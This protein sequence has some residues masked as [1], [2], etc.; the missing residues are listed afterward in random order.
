MTSEVASALAVLAAG[1]IAVLFR[2]HHWLKDVE[3]KL[4]EVR[5]E[6]TAELVRQRATAYEAF[7]LKIEPPRN[8]WSSILYG[9]IHYVEHGI[10]PLTLCYNPGH[11]NPITPEI[12]RVRR[13]RILARDSARFAQLKGP[14]AV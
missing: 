14:R 3:I 13:A 12:A 10:A 11:N 8:I 5:E 2:H 6:I 1:M 7:F 4:D 9:A